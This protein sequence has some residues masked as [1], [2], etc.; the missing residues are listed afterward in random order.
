MK[1]IFPRFGIPKE[2]DTPET[3][4]Y[5]LIFTGTETKTIEYGKP[6]YFLAYYLRFDKVTKT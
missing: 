1:F 2:F 4:D 5:N 6:F 3:K